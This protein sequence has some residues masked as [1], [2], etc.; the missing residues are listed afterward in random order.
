MFALDETYFFF[1]LTW[2]PDAGIVKSEETSIAR[3][4][5]DKH[6]PAEKNSW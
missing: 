6:F 5:L 2:G 4:R 1:I 3:Q